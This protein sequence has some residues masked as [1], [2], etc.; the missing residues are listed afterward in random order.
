MIYQEIP[1]I[2]IMVVS[3]HKIHFDVVLPSTW[4]LYS[5]I[6]LDLWKNNTLGQ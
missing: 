5:V 3:N 2:D 4:L 1:I 6:V